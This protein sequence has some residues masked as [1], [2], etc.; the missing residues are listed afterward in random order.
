MTIGRMRATFIRCHFD[1]RLCVVSDTTQG[2][3]VPG[4]VN[5]LIFIWCSCDAAH[6]QGCLRKWHA[7]QRVCLLW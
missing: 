4:A 7:G 6:M 3:D 1:S 2:A 5:S